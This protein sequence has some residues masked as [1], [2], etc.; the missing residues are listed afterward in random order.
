MTMNKFVIVCDG[1]NNEKHDQARITDLIDGQLKHRCGKAVA[2]DTGTV[3]LLCPV[4]GCR[5]NAKLNPDTAQAI[6]SFFDE[7]LALTVKRAV[8]ERF[9]ECGSTKQYP[10]VIRLATICRVLT[11]FRKIQFITGGKR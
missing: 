2:D 7:N 1:R 11:D 10:P 9:V 4:P 6:A 3:K 5:L 8:P